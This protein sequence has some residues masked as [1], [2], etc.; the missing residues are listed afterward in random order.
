MIEISCVVQEH[1][2]DH[3]PMLSVQ[4]QKRADNVRDASFRNWSWVSWL[5]KHK[6]INNI[7]YTHCMVLP[8]LLVV[9][10]LVITSQRA[11]NIFHIVGVSH[12][13]ILHVHQNRFWTE[14]WL[15]FAINGV[16]PLL[17]VSVLSSLKVVGVN[18][19]RQPLIM[20]IRHSRK[21]G[22]SDTLL[23]MIRYSA[24]LRLIEWWECLEIVIVALQ[25]IRRLWD[26]YRWY[27]GIFSIK[28]IQRKKWSHSLV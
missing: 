21:N 7:D 27:I 2:S 22:R 6:G 1:V 11:V 20:A 25:I 15:V 18:I 8:E 9:N 13:I 14:L 5:C 10:H 17:A 12:K 3:L 16:T 4:Q 28:N 24:V 26:V 19:G 23:A